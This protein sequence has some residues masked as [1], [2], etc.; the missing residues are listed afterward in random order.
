[1]VKNAG[2]PS[3]RFIWGK[4][5]I[6]YSLQVGDIVV[7]EIG[8]GNE[9]RRM[10]VNWAPESVWNGVKSESPASKTAGKVFDLIKKIDLPRLDPEKDS[11]VVIR[12]LDSNRRQLERGYGNLA[13]MLDR[14]QEDIVIF[15]HVGNIIEAQIKKCWVQIKNPFVKATVTQI[16]A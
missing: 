4:C 1:M 15:S 12:V 10:A 13:K 9:K 6:S 8:D 3:A 5:L 2:T 14:E 7:A 16:A 11:S